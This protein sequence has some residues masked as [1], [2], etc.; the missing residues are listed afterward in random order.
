MNRPF[1]WSRIARKL[2]GSKFIRS[3]VFILANRAAICN[4]YIWNYETVYAIL[5]GVNE[6]QL[7]YCHT[8]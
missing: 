4:L 2:S 7:Q 8:I 3:Q 6:K 1:H 5:K